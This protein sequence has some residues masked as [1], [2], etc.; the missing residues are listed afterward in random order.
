MLNADLC[1]IPVL[2]G[3]GKCKHYQSIIFINKKMR[4][5][6]QP[7]FNFHFITLEETLKE[8]ALLS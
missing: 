3:V 2:I 5:K 4:E 7:K 1:I 6:G 8:V